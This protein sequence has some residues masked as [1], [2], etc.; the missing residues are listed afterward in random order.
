MS[1]ILTI[2]EYRVEKEKAKFNEKKSD[3]ELEGEIKNKGEEFR[4]KNRYKN[5][6]PAVRKREKLEASKVKMNG[7]EKKR[8]G[9]QLESS[10]FN[11]NGKEMCK[12]EFFFSLD[13]LFFCCSL[14]RRVL[15]FHDFIFCLSKS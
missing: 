6:I 7:S 3:R 13:L 2:L 5:S 4:W 1:T 11:K 10:T 12:S 15:T 9:A 14:C 8:T